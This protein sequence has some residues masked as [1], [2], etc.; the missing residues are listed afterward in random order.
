MAVIEATRDAARINALYYQHIPARGIPEYWYPVAM[1]HEISERPCAMVIHGQEIALLRRQGKVY[2]IANACPHRGARLHKGTCEF[3]GSATLTCRYHGW[4]FDLASGELAA[5]LT[6]GPDSPIAGKVRARTYPAE[7]RQGIVWLWMG[8]GRP[9]PVEQDIPPGLLMASEVHTVRRICRGNWRWHAENPGLGHATMLHRDSAYMRMVDFF[10]YGKGMQAHLME[11]GVDG[12]WLQ[13]RSTGWGK[14]E[15]YPGL[16]RWPRH[17]FGEVFRIQELRPTLGVS[18]IVS[19]RLPGVVRINNYPFQG[20]MYYEWFVQTD[21][22]HY[23]YFQVDCGFPQNWRQRL[24]Y[25]LNY[26]LWGRFIGVVRF[27]MQDIDMVGDGHDYAL[28]HGHNDPAPLYRPDGFHLA[29]RKYALANLR[30]G[31]VPGF[32]DARSALVPAR[33]A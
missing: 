7:V 9:V 17:R 32:E 18:T 30:G 24:W 25:R 12:E 31:P 20:A 5:A 14:G 15:E 13:E 21:A 8:Q 10:G 6:D 2:A 1:A 28:A 26:H 16:G 27:T 19:I 22:D 29:W 23:L 33:A 11:E 4:T 3:P